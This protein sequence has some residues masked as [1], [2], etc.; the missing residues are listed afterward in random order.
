MMERSASLIALSAEFTASL[1]N[2]ARVSQLVREY[3]DRVR[4]EPGNIAFIAHRKRDNPAEFFVYEEYAD[5]TAFRDH[6]GDAAGVAFNRA[7]V[8]LIVGHGSALT[9]LCPL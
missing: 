4:A 7:L 1:G 6:L 2:E 5:A 3:G 8:D 9:F